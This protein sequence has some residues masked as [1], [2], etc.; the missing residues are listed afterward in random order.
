MRD[1][2]RDES[3]DLRK[4]LARLNGLINE[5]TAAYGGVDGLKTFHAEALR[6]LL[7][8]QEE[9]QKVEDQIRRYDDAAGAGASRGPLSPE[10]IAVDS[11]EMARD[12]LDLDRLK[13]DEARLVGKVGDQ[14]P[15]LV[16]TRSD[17][18][19]L[20]THIQRMADAWN[21]KRLAGAQGGVTR[22][23]LVALEERLKT[24]RDALGAHRQELGDLLA[25]VARHQK[26]I[27]DDQR[28]LDDLK[29]LR[30]NVDLK[31]IGEGRITIPE[32]GPP[33]T[34][35]YKDSRISRAVAGAV[36]GGGLCFLLVIFLGF[37]DRRV[38]SV[39]D[40]DQAPFGVRLLGLLPT[41]PA[42]V[43]DPRGEEVA[44]HCVHHI[45]TL[46][47]ITQAGGRGP[48]SF[49][50]TS[51]GPG[52][53]KTTLAAALGLSFA[54]SGTRTL[55][56][57]A[58]LEGRGLTRLIG[59]LLLGRIRRRADALPEPSTPEPAPP[60]F[61][62]PA[63]RLLGPFV[64]GRMREPLPTP[65]EMESLLGRALTAFGVRGAYESG[66]LGDIFS[67]TD[68]AL[69]GAGRE[70]LEAILREA[71]SAGGDGADA[72]P[73]DLVPPR[74]LEISPERAAV[75]GTGLGPLLYR[76]GVE[77]LSFVPLR[78][79]VTGG[80]VSATTLAGLVH[81]VEAEFETVLIDTGPVPG[82]LETS[83][84]AAE[85]GR[86][87]MVVSL[88]DPRPEYLRAVSHLA[89]VGARMAGVVFNRAGLREVIRT[90]RT[91]LRSGG[92]EA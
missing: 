24:E 9:F 2:L 21:A 51:P 41:L 46:L 34:T 76:T 8:A 44:I 20:K 52:S 83:M 29:Y 67:M 19:V 38:R 62:I 60:G 5:K 55:L 49:C 77:N 17:I 81:A 84:V 1:K 54:A 72:F 57:D 3:E 58:D 45:R 12:L 26:D 63:R 88:G 32:P 15:G 22:E 35:P 70:D 85:V 64:A 47:Q 92:G 30:E 90:S 11:A 74:V 69:H 66:I 68:L 87:V 6:T 4:D 36:G 50:I 39:E 82:S 75:N 18:G 65:E 79:L 10:E 86:V 56:V 33:P 42:E 31:P 53:G 48:S 7:S 80:A 14:D 78:G 37:L 61:E 25:E 13:A 43:S 59:Q 71:A 91:S 40:V 28:K 27:D 23:Q 73:E 89:E 16:K